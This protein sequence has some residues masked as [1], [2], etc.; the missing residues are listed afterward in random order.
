MITSASVQD[1]DAAM[2]IVDLAKAKVP[3]IQALFVDAGYAGA[4]A[5]EIRARHDIDVQVVRHPGNRNVGTWVHEQA[6]LSP[7]AD[8]GFVI[9]PRRWIIERTNA[10]RAA[11]TDSTRITTATS[12]SPKPGSGWPKAADSSAASPPRSQQA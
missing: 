12:R 3:G 5:R 10:H 1:R 2:T 8:R 7:V 6:P 11:R 4:R 9:L